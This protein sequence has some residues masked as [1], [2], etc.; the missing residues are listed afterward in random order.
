MHNNENTGQ[1]LHYHKPASEWNEALPIGNGIL[2]AMVFGNPLQ[3]RIQL[4]EDSLWY[5]GPRDRHNPDALAN[6][7]EIRRLIFA[8]Q[9]KEAEQLASLALTGTPESQRHYQPLGDLFLN[10]NPGDRSI[11]ISDYERELDLEQ[12][13]VRV[14]YMSMGITYY[15]EVFA[16]YPDQVIIVRLWADQPGMI[17]LTARLGRERWRY[18]GGIEAL[19]GDTLLMGGATG[20]GGVTYHAALTCRS[21]GGSSRTLGEH[22]IVESADTVTLYLSAATTFRQSDPRAYCLEVGTVAA[23]REYSELL[24]GHIIDYRELY[25]RVSLNLQGDNNTTQQT[26][27]TAQQLAALFQEGKDDLQLITLYFQYGRY[28]LIS[29]SRPGSLP[30]NLQGIWNDQMLPPWDS[31]YTI[32]IN[33]Q[34]NYWLAESCNLSECHEPLFDLIERMRIS[35]RATA[36]RMYDCRGIAAHH[37][38]DIW[39]DTAPQ[40]SYLPSTY[41]PLGL[42][43]LS[44]HLWEHYEFTQDK[45]FLEKHYATMR[46]SARFLLDYLVEGPD[47]Q[48]V[49]CP[50]VSP[51]NTY[52]L[53]NGESGV[54]C[55][56]SSMDN[57]IMHALFTACIEA[58]VLLN[59]D[60]QFREELETA[61]GSLMPP[62]IGKH[63]RLLEWSE[64]YEE[65]EPGHRHISHLFALHP[66]KQITPQS[67]PLLANAA[68]SSL[69]HRLDSGGGHTGWS[70]AWIINFWARLHDGDEAYA[71]LL[72]LLQHSTLPNL[73]D[74]HPP[75]QIDGNFGAA[76]GIT[77]MLLQSHAGELH[78]L[79]ALP[80]AWSSGSVA[81]LRARGGLT[82][83]L[84]WKDGRLLQAELS[85]THSGSYRIHCSSP[86]TVWHKDKQLEWSQVAE[87]IIEVKLKAG[88][89]V[90]LLPS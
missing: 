4:N 71:N 18:L 66:G 78:L 80:K 56:G 17:S 49:T 7:P 79:P 87:D 48:L 21:E 53:P 36:E 55:Y 63:G 64:D 58:E 2:G 9:L 52:I 34:M 30:A 75:F 46:D 15:R 31:K 43:W 41:W 25:S 13:V 69:L 23:K 47:R 72:A 38:T 12:A 81:G 19:G 6:L 61:L 59:E 1:R 74:N 28:L 83:S 51:E 86:L 67:T 26:G 60:S 8:G 32:N 44:L 39:A 29:S 42:A 27:D 73:F 62:Q 40:D 35:G 20:D 10:L 11:Q 33:T 88:E 37:N 68:R 24:A 3:E 22:W 89:T 14:S 70:R 16:S 65:K 54:L 77:E 90:L 82:V 57:Q 45:V 85:P 50:S 76:A 84:G 5:G